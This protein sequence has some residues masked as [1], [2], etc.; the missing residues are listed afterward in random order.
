VASVSDRIHAAG[1][2]VMRDGQVAVVHRA[3]YDDWTLPKG[4]LDSGE[5][6]EEAALREVEEE[7]GLRGVLVRELPATMYNV[8]G[9]PKVVRYWLMEVEHEASFVP[10]DETDQLRWVTL[11]E[12]LRLLTYDRDRDVVRSLGRS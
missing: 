1:G 9:R 4:K 12:A 10:N 2:V 8:G 6:F 7:T 5:S 3:R 11:D